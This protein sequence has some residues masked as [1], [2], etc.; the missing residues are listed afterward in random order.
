M[1]PASQ[2]L[3]EYTNAPA[4]KF[5]RSVISENPAILSDI[6]QEDVNIAI[7]KR[8]ITQTLQAAIDE[9]LNSKPELRII[10]A[11]SPESVNEVLRASLGDTY[12]T[13]ELN[14]NIR[15]MV[16]MFCYLF[17]LKNV[18]LRLTTLD[19]A[20][21]P[22]FHFDNVPVRLITTYHGVATEWLPHNVIDR[23]KLGAGSL[24]LSDDKSGLYQ[25]SDDIQSC[26]VGD[27]ALLK[28][29]R[30]EGNEDAGLVHRSPTVP[31]G[32]NRLILTLDV[33]N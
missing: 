7:W 10:E 4:L 33:I 28:G 9:L 32:E 15:D 26:G 19:R 1:N 29:E 17:D 8:E 20:M 3:T 6:Y 11:V 5:R 30:W 14:T 13:K 22:K 23:S 18:G 24:G 16:E 31:S 2:N 21:C 27:V 12:S 25:N